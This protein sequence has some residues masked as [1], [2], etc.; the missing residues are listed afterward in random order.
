VLQYNHSIVC[1]LANS[2]YEVTY[3]QEVP[4]DLVQLMG[5]AGIDQLRQKAAQMVEQQKLLGVSQQVWL[6]A[7]TECDAEQ[8]LS[9]VSPDLIVFSNGAPIANFLPKRLAIQ[10]NIPFVVVEGLVHP[11]QPPA[12]WA[13][14]IEEL[15]THYV[16]AKAVIAVSQDNLRLLRKFFKLP[17]HKGQVI[18][19][20]R[21]ARYFEPPD[22]HH[23]A[24]LRQE[25]GIPADAVVC[26]TAA[27]LDIIKG[28]QYQIG[29]I[30]QL[31]QT[32]VWEKLH[33]AWAGQGTLVEQL[34]QSVKQM[35]IGDRIKFLGEL[36]DIVDWLDASDIFVLP[37]EAEGMPLSIM[38]AMAKGLPVVATSISGIPEELGETGHLLPSPMLDAQATIR[39]L[40][41][42]IQAWGS[43]KALR[44]E[45][46]Q[47]CQRRAEQMFQEERMVRETLAVIQANLSMP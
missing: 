33:F 1:A 2:G 43:D 13:A 9:K 24:R 47:A 27:R 18:H 30:K 22:P 46:G 32:P 38:E 11:T 20:G 8:V 3:V 25:F 14:G 31:R 45:I 41:E 4:Q 39:S 21:P 44:L 34:K 17:E 15:A 10:K 19:S 7:A 29:A 42:T 36:A 28:Y 6:E 12:S 16:Q 40:A 35:G 26:F 37:S 5:R 23:R